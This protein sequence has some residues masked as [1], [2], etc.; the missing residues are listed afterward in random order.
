MT[1]F[2]IFDEVIPRRTPRGPRPARNFCKPGY[3]RNWQVVSKI[4]IRI[5]GECQC[6]GSQENLTVHHAGIPFADGR[7]NSSRNKHDLRLENL[8]VL[9]APCHLH[10]ELATIRIEGL[11]P[12]APGTGLAYKR[13]QRRRHRKLN[14][15][16]GLVPMKG[17]CS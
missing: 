13:K 15:G 12:G 4:L 8:I 11:Q 9:C 14:I 5:I 17:T 1:S 2:E 16:T 7:P 3:P 6:C 10:I